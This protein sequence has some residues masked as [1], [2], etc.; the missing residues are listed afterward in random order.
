MPNEMTDRIKPRYAAS[1]SY[2]DTPP[3]GRQSITIGSEAKISTPKCVSDAT[4]LPSTIA[5]GRSGLASSI[6]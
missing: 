6:S 5:A 3:S 1:T 4:S 2:S